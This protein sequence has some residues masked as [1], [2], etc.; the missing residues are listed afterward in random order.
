[1]RK[2]I[3]EV[4]V[5]SAQEAVAA[6]AGGADRLELAAD[7]EVDGIAPSVKEFMR[8]RDAVGIPLRIML[9]DRGGFQ[10]ADPEE[11]RAI[12]SALRAEGAEEFVL[13]FLTSDGALDLLAVQ[14]LLEVIPG[15]RWTFHR[16]LDHAADRHAVRRAI[17]GL[18]GL[19]TVLSAGCV[20]Q[21]RDGLDVLT[22]EAGRQ[23]E[24]GY[25]MAMMAGGGLEPKDLP[26]LRARGIGAFHIGTAAR[27]GAWDTP[28]DPIAVRC[29]RQHI[30]T[31]LE[32]IPPAARRVD[33]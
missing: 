20:T 32:V 11:L 31:A 15:C 22:E 28:V 19:D 26:P 21:V 27:Q 23:G 9:R 29:W 1:M 25:T 30:E 4:V 33:V 16:A 12:A 17:D 10:P 3:L 18:P 6:T 24:P 7:L 8:T 13:G 14:A 2:P 5:T